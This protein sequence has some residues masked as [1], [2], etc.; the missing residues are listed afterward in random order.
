LRDKI[1]YQY[2]MG[3]IYDEI[4]RDDIALKYYQAA[5]DLG[6]NERYYFAS[7]ATP[8]I[9]EIYERRMDVQRSKYYYNIT[10]NM[11]GRD[12]ENSIENRAKEGFN[13]L[14]D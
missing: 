12:Y 2:R 13:G 7:N 10:I 1:E 5:I 9:A 11:N 8:R 6:K 4:S 3:L 14:G